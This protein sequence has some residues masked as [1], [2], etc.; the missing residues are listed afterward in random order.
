M[1][2]N[3]ILS[4][5]K[6]CR[7]GGFAVKNG[8]CA[9]YDFVAFAVS[10]SHMFN[11]LVCPRNGEGQLNCGNAA[12]NAGFCNSLGS[13]GAFRPDNGNKAAVGY[14][15]DDFGSVHLFSLPIHFF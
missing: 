4:T 14:F 6:D 7:S 13:V 2:R 11:E 12:F 10:A 8:S 3:N 1:G 15:F 9:D 5:G